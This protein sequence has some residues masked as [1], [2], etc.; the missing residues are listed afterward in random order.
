MPIKMTPTR[1]VPS[2]AQRLAERRLKRCMDIAKKSV[3]FVF[4]SDDNGPTYVTLNNARDIFEFECG[5]LR[6]YALDPDDPPDMDW[7]IY[8]DEHPIRARFRWGAKAVE[9]ESNIGPTVW[10]WRSDLAVWVNGGAFPILMPYPPQP[11]P[12]AVVNAR[13]SQDGGWLITDID[14]DEPLPPLPA[15]EEPSENLPPS[16][17]AIMNAR[18]SQD[19]DCGIHTDITYEPAPLDDFG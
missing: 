1:V 13:I 15:R 19:E 4:K 11:T 17:D 16:P 5:A 8:D 18:I 9:F 12:D 6:A 7:Q 2:K 14:Y 10:L 3:V